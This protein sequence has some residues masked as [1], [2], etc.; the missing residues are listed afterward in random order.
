MPA[1]RGPR[2]PIHYERDALGY[3][4]IRARDV[5]D[6]AYCLGHLHARDRLLQI[7][8][9]VCLAQGRAM[10]LFGDAPLFRLLDR[11]SRMFDF[12]GDLGLQTSRFDDETRAYL[13]SYCSGFNAAA[14]RR[15]HRVI[16]KM[17]GV[18]PGPHTP[19]SMVL[20]YRLVSFF[21]L[22]SMQHSGEATITE[23][24]AAGAP[25]RLIALLLGEP[26]SAF[27]HLG[28]LSKLEVPPEL[29]YVVPHLGG[30]NAFAVAPS[31]SASGGAL[32]MAEPH[33][34]IA[35]F[36][37]ILYA[38]HI[39]YEDGTYYQG[40][41][42]PGIPWLSFGRT[43][44]VGWA[45]TYGHGDN[46][47]CLVERVADGRYLAAGEWKPL[48]KR[49]YEVRVR[50]RSPERWTFWENDYGTIVG[51]AERGGDFA[52]V[53]WSGLREIWRDI[54]AALPAMRA[55]DVIELA[56]HY[57]SVRCVSLNAV[58][59]DRVGNIALV[60][61][62]QVDVRPPGWTGATPY[63]GWDLASRSPRVLGEDE[64]PHVLN[65]PEGFIATANE[66]R[67]GPHGERWSTLPEPRYRRE[68]LSEILADTPRADLDA[69]VRASYD[70]IDRCAERLL[71]VWGRHLPAAAQPMVR[72]ATRQAATPP[73]E[74]RKMIGLFHT[75]HTEA[76]R[77]L[78]SR[79]VSGSSARRFVYEM[80]LG[81]IFQEHLDC[82]FALERPEVLSAHDL[83]SVLAH[84][85]PAALDR[86]SRKKAAAPIEAGF[87][88][89][90][91]R[92]LLPTALGFDLAP[93]ELPGGPTSPFQMRK[94]RV[95][96]EDLVFGPALHYAIDMSKPGG[97]YHVPGGASEERLGPGYGAGVD[98]WMSGRFIALGDAE[99][100]PPSL[101]PHAR[102]PKP[103]LRSR[104]LSQRMSGRRATS[105]VSRV[106]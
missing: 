66:R 91:M 71:P 85:W 94:V 104:I 89:V 58:L 53:R 78:I 6:G 54:C 18:D 70:E 3:P 23:L 59:V 36:P 40:V 60:Q 76:T 64:R 44:N 16:Y 101:M 100:E 57:R 67:D 79:W 74:H 92:G 9:A 56:L 12:Q 55:R 43:P 82:A 37:P 42:V 14:S 4:R 95:L 62:G 31:R 1:V 50:G 69:L 22:T 90:I 30:S 34:E 33:M 7:Q 75:L 48:R 103:S 99:G 81:V 63:P 11:V 83:E 93:A 86:V 84:A 8:L 77:V 96:R 51:D 28:A 47:D 26:E 39:D 72:W 105:P 17:L 35:R 32:L 98:L 2:G 73:A 46:V 25:K 68:R 19:E 80:S 13:E 21:G 65:P 41:G 20:L 102:K 15:G 5:V 52:C 24:V 38:A 10:E 45:M 29:R 106:K 97:F 49:S 61:T 88:N 87:K 27:D